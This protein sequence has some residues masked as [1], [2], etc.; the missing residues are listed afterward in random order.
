M[1]KIILIAVI[2]CF[3]LSSHAQEQD[4][5]SLFEGLL[6]IAEWV[7]KINSAIE[8]MDNRES[9]KR[10]KRELSYLSTD[11]NEITSSKKRLVFK[12]T[13]PTADRGDYNNEINDLQEAVHIF[14]KRFENINQ[15]IPAEFKVEGNPI[16]QEIDGLISGKLESL[17]KVKMALYGSEFNNTDIIIELNKAIELTQKIELKINSIK[18][19]I[20]TKLE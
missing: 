11:I 13:K 2:A 15:I 9:L 12:A 14:K 5:A 16:T 7:D 1:K 10:L 8:D 19:N 3:P 4:K 6:N 20:E 18:L 17:E